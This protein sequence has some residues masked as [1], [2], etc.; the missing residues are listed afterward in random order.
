MRSNSDASK[1]GVYNQDGGRGRGVMAGWAVGGGV[2]AGAGALAMSRVGNS[3]EGMESIMGAGKIMEDTSMNVGRR[4]LRVAGRT[5]EAMSAHGGKIGKLM[6][7]KYALGKMA[8]LAAAGGIIG[9]L[10]DDPNQ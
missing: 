9:G 1:Q 8:G 3:M 10:L 6:G 7:G 2:A 4:A 5:G